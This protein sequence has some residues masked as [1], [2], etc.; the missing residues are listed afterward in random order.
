MLL[1][2]KKKKKSIYYSEKYWC[3]QTFKKSNCKQQSTENHTPDPQSIMVSVVFWHAEFW[4][5][6]K[7][8]LKTQTVILYAEEHLSCTATATTAM[9]KMTNVGKIIGVETNK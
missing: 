6:W 9:I 7:Q 3:K 4:Q 8:P 1:I 2:K 5:V